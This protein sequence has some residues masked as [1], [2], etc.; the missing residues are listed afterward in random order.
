MRLSEEEADKR[1]EMLH[2]MVAELC[3]ECHQHPEVQ[4]H[5][6]D[7]PTWEEE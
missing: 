3:G 7:C 5:H 2:D 1:S 6:E 4:G